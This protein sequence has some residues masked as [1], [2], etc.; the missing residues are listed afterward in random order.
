MSALQAQLPRM[1]FHHLQ[2][3]MG[4]PI[5]AHYPHYQHPYHPQLPMHIR[6][7]QQNMQNQMPLRPISAPYPNPN[8]F[9]PAAITQYPPPRPPVMQPGHHQ[10]GPQNNFASGHMNGIHFQPSFNAVANPL[11][12]TGIH[13]NRS[14]FATGFMP[15]TG[16]AITHNLPPAFQP[17]SNSTLTA[18]YGQQT[19][20]IPVP[21]GNQ[22]SYV[23]PVTFQ[24]GIKPYPFP[25]Y[26]RSLARNEISSNLGSSQIMSTPVNQ[27]S[28]Q[29]AP[30]NV[31]T[32]PTNIPQ[33]KPSFSIENLGVSNLLNSEMVNFAPSV[34]N[35]KRQ[36]SE[37]DHTIEEI[38]NVSSYCA[39]EPQLKSFCYQDENFAPQSVASSTSEISQ[40]TPQ[41]PEI[42]NIND[43]NACS[44]TEPLH[45]SIPED[46][47]S[48]CEQSNATLPGDENSSSS[49]NLLMPKLDL[50]VISQQSQQM[51]PLSQL[52][53][54]GNFN[55]TP[56]QDAQTEGW[57]FA[58]MNELENINPN[59]NMLHSA[60]NNFW[61][62]LPRS[63]LLPNEN[64]GC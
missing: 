15:S 64:Q 39:S 55:S 46:S 35:K 20:N 9:T 8:S 14:N 3:P 19:G 13:S 42:N 54:M 18:N 4:H 40:V 11:H 31:P 24:N 51:Y 53:N 38:S 61:G 22:G 37:V 1:P 63:F 50:P 60:Q 57:N 48:F 16:S 62:S 27:Q 7:F 49:S 47:R 44:S 25:N 41:T 52:Q 5:M 43:N 2:H 26:A 59:E 36:F 17:A 58:Q 56:A 6:P 28:R 34:A 10:L 23:N 32:G 33:F 12:A 21:T 30:C 45:V 29:L